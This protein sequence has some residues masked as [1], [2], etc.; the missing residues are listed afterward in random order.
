[1]PYYRWDDGLLIGVPLCDEHHQ[2]L[3]ALFNKTHDEFAAQSSSQD[4]A[5]LFRE[6]IDYAAYHFTIEE[7][8]MTQSD[9]PGREEHIKE[10][11]NF[12]RRVEEMHQAH[13]H[14]QEHL[15]REVLTFL[16]NWIT[17]HIRKLDARFG[18]F[19]ACSR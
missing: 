13:C 5:A 8:L 14:G 11:R 7:R 9:F 4:I 15:N 10:H 18:R 12:S 2:H 3:F 17:T 1:M 19:M 16:A 6:L